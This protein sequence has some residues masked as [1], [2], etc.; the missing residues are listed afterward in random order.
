[1]KEAALRLGLDVWEPGDLK[2]PEFFLLFQNENPDLIV[3]AAYGG[4]IPVEILNLPPRGAVNLHPSLLPRYRGAAPVQ[5]AL[6]AGEAETGVTLAM[7]SEKWDAGEILAQEKFSVR[8]D[9]DAGSLLDRLAIEAAR[10]L[11]NALPAILEGKAARTPQDHAQATFAP[12][13]KKEDQRI[14]WNAPARGVV[15]RIRGL[16]PEP[17]ARAA[18]GGAGVTIFKASARDDA[19]AA[20]GPGVI[21]RVEKEGPVVAAGSGAVVI[22]RLQ[23]DSRKILTGREFVNGYR[24]QAGQTFGA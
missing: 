14:D 17:G 11:K 20:A 18:F 5:R 4:Y 13:I 19:G 3:S 15:N 1:M 2:A 22:E 24:V 9:D 7:M 12:A 6:M 23:P 8:P 10:I 16:A 21:V